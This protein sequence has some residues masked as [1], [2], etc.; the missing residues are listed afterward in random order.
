MFRFAETCAI[1]KKTQPS[2]PGRIMPLNAVPA[3]L[4]SACLENGIELGASFDDLPGPFEAG[5]DDERG[6]RTEL[7]ALPLR[8]LQ[9]DQ[10]FGQTTEFRFRISDAPLPRRARPASREE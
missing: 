9:R 2:R 10:T 3:H 8:V 4:L 1:V 6:P 7:P 5:G